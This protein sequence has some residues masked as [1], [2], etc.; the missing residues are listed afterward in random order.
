M[1]GLAARNCRRRSDRKRPGMMPGPQL[2]GLINLS[3]F[4]LRLWREG[5]L[6]FSQITVRLMSLSRSDPGSRLA[7]LRQRFVR[8]RHRPT[9]STSCCSSTGRPFKLGC[10]LGGL[11]MEPRPHLALIWSTR[12]IPPLA[13][14]TGSGPVGACPLNNP[15]RPRPSRLLFSEG[16]AGSRG[17]VSPGA[18]H[19][20]RSRVFWARGRPGVGTRRLSHRA[21]TALMR[22]RG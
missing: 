11:A 3:L 12:G 10:P 9:I 15:D 19:P 4:T 6:C 22:L 5:V 20:D 17:A 2:A 21:K 18:A 13:T 14:C 16:V 7:Y 8:R 1:A